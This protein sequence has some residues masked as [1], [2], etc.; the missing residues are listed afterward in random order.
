MGE[1]KYLILIHVE[2][3]IPESADDILKEIGFDSSDT[4]DR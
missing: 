4:A 1:I 3:M 2:I